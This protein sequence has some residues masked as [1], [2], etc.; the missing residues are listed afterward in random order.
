MGYL[1]LEGLLKVIPYYTH[2]LV[3]FASTAGAYAPVLAWQSWRGRSKG[4]SA[5]TAR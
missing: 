1:A 4:R 2:W 3:T 5:G